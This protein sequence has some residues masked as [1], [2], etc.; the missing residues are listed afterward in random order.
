MSVF[1]LLVK[2]APFLWGFSGVLRSFTVCAQVVPKTP[3]SLLPVED[4]MSR[5]KLKF[6]K[7]PK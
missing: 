2:V 7:W 4:V 1:N 6:A 5:R 3:D